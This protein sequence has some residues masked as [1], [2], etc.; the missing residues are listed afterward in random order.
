M[1]LE[2]Q[3]VAVKRD[4][5]VVE[6]LLSD[7]VRVVGR[8]VEVFGSSDKAMR[9]LEAPVPSLGHR[10]PLSMLTTASGRAEV[11]DTMGAIEHGIW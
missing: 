2:E 10:T 11:E 5:P 7:I 4:S 3:T 8:A 6:I 1:Q 9:W